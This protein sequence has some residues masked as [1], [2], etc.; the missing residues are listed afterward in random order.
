MGSIG[1]QYLCQLVSMYILHLVNVGLRPAI[2]SLINSCLFQV[3]VIHMN[4][5]YNLLDHWCWWKLPR[6]ASYISSLIMNYNWWLIQLSSKDHFIIYFGCKYNAIFH[7]QVLNYLIYIYMY[8]S[9]FTRWLL[10]WTINWWYTLIIFDLCPG[11]EACIY[12]HI[13][14]F[15]ILGYKL[16]MIMLMISHGLVLLLLLL[17]PIVPSYC[18]T[19]IPL[20]LNMCL[21]IYIQ[22]I[23]MYTAKLWD[24]GDIYRQV[25][26][27]ENRNFRCR[28]KLK[29]GHLQYSKQHEFLDFYYYRCHLTGIRLISNFECVICIKTHA[30]CWNQWGKKNL[31]E[32]L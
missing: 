21:Y 9:I 2:W 12:I 25:P 1:V 29:N 26:V 23:S 30:R 5:L 4:T 3:L 32:L 19:V 8:P 6:I 15:P 10:Y 17:T 20:S 14:L 28:C 13:E 7:I 18:F 16:Y 27:V 11:Y 22:P 24:F 31:E